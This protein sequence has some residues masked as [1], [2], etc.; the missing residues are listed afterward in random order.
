MLNEKERKICNE[1]SDQIVESAKVVTMK[2]DNRVKLFYS[3]FIMKKDNRFKSIIAKT[4][5]EFSELIAQQ[6][7]K[8]VKL[9]KVSA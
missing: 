4:E 8:Y 6:L 9:Q 5:Q 3:D 7:N 1:L 2:N